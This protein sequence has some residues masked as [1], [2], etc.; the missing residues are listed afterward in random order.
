MAGNI[1]TINKDEEYFIEDEEVLDQIRGILRESSVKMKEGGTTVIEDDLVVEIEQT[2]SIHSKY[3][4]DG[5]QD[6]S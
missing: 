2:A 3:S 5:E 1:I 4:K 6:E